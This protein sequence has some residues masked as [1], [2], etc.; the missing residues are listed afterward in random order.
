MRVVNPVMHL[1]F[2]GHI[3][4]PFALIPL[5]WGE[6][7]QG[8]FWLALATALPIWVLGLPKAPKVPP[9]LRPVLAIHLAPAS[10][11]ATVAA[12]LGWPGMA[13][14]LGLWAAVLALVLAARLPWL[15]ASGFSPFWGALTFPLAAFAQAA[16][17]GLGQPG[18]WL[19]AGL[20]VVAVVAIPWI[21]W[22]VLKLWPGGRL[23]RLT[24][25]AVA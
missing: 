7:A 1:V 5:G 15:L 18:L 2:L 8:L 10:V 4:A 19:G 3:L 9:P 24:N 22:R 17:W 14:G 13:L 11:L 20:A 25:A 6:L 23:A 21:A 16:V 12:Y